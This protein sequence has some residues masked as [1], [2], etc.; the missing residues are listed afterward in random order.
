MDI[1]DSIVL[2]GISEIINTHVELSL[3]EFIDIT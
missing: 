1:D 3:L 2:K